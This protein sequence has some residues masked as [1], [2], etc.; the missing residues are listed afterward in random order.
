[1][2][3]PL[4]ETKICAFVHF[5]KKRAQ[6]GTC[7]RLDIQPEKNDLISGQIDLLRH[8]YTVARM[9]ERDRLFSLNLSS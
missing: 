1:M 8:L 4:V 3:E 9:C 7:S 5:A 6:K 2:L